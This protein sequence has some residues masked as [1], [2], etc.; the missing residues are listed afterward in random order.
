MATLTSLVLAAGTFQLVEN[1]FPLSFPDTMSQEQSRIDY[2]VT[3]Q[4]L[5]RSSFNDTLLSRYTI[6]DQN[7]SLNY[8]FNDFSITASWNRYVFDIDDAFNSDYTKTSFKPVG[9]AFRLRSDILFG[10]WKIRPGVSFT[11]S[12]TNDTLFIEEYPR[13]DQS[14]M[15]NYFFDLLPETYGDS[16]HFRHNYHSLN[17]ELTAHHKALTFHLS[18]FYSSDQI[19]ETHANTSSNI[20]LQGPRES[21]CSFNQSRI[22]ARIGWT[23]R[24]DHYLWGG[25]DYHTFPLDW[26]HTVYPGDPIPNEIIQLVI[27][28]SNLFR[29]QLGYN[30]KINKFNIRTGIS[31]GFANTADTASTPVMGYFLNIFPISHQASLSAGTAYIMGQVHADYLWSIKNTKIRPRLDILASRFWSNIDFQALL[32]FGLEDIQISDN[33]IHAAYVAALG[34]DADIALNQDLYLSLKIEQMIPYVKAVSPVTPP[35]PPDGIKRYGGLS[36]SAGVYMTW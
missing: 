32:E 25:L 27:G 7:L 26:R 20:K 21:L 2:S 14:A 15:N 11:F 34:C 31:S 9:H 19:D 6:K 13:S 3:H 1:A 5:Y 4:E 24:P 28:K 16:I 29:A 8:L 36:I 17:G 10:S 30:T 33:Y 35:P 12:S 18:Y 22:K 23:M